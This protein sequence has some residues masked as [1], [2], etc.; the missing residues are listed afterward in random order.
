VDF[1]RENQCLIEL[2]T[3][4]ILLQT[5]RIVQRTIE[6][7]LLHIIRIIAG[8]VDRERHHIDYRMINVIFGTIGE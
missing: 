8:L 2:F 6:L 1:G 7:F 5:N 3:A 4:A